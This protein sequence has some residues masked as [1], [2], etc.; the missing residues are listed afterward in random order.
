MHPM[1]K[2]TNARKI[3]SQV[4]LGATELSKLYNTSS[5][6]QNVKAWNKI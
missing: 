4:K 5:T 1:E 2:P 3:I 6:P